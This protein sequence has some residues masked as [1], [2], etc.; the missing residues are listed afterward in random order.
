MQKIV[1]WLHCLPTPLEIS[2]QQ[3]NQQK[4]QNLKRQWK[5]F[6]RNFL[7]KI[8][9]RVLKKKSYRKLYTKVSFL[10][11]KNPHGSSKRLYNTPCKSA[12]RFRKSALA[13]LA[14]IRF[15][16]AERLPKQE[17]AV[18]FADLTKFSETAFAYYYICTKFEVYFLH[19]K[20]CS[21][22]LLPSKVVKYKVFLIGTQPA[23]HIGKKISLK[24]AYPIE[25]TL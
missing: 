15:C 12:N 2:S 9:K 6:L 21:T 16:N 3:S 22:A 23:Q 1:S 24:C 17:S 18:L 5:L 20:R 13:D 4:L 19:I 25:N 8:F 14:P 11:D 7:G 10:G